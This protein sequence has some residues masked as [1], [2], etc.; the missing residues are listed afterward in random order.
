MGIRATLPPAV[1]ILLAVLPLGAATDSLDYLVALVRDSMAHQQSDSKL[2]RAL[3]RVHLEQ[4]MDPRTAEELES[5][6]PGP[7]SIAGIERLRQ[8]SREKPL[9]AM[10]PVFPSPPAPT[11]DELRD[12]LRDARLIALAYTA[13]LP[14]FICTQ[15]VQRYID[16]LALHRTVARDTLTVQLT[17]YEREENYKLMEWNGHPTWLTYDSLGGALSKGEFGTMLFDV[18]TPASQTVFEWSNWTTLRRRTAYVLA[19]RIDVR[20]SR[21]RITVGQGGFPS[22][23]TAAGQHGLLYIDRET[24]EVRRVDC[25]ADSIPGDFPIKAATRGLDY[26]PAEVGGHSYLLPLHA[27]TRMEIR[28]RPMVQRNELD[29]SGYRRFTGESKISF[30]GP[31]DETPAAP[32]GR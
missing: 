5:A 31:A 21:Y 22:A 3:E 19:F 4:R 24:R 18:F 14:D 16:N 20:N 29:F 9:P 17:Y 1:A 23:T 2:A 27:E 6:A 7:E 25:E 10:L 11:M 30:G 12:L 28:N 15:S 13:S 26:G 8:A 32:S